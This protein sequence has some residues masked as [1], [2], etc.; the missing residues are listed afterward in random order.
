M[1]VGERIESGPRPEGATAG[2]HTES[3]A[4]ERATSPPAPGA[5]GAGDVPRRESRAPHTIVAIDD[6]PLF[7]E[8]L[9]A[10]F[11]GDKE[12][13]LVGDASNGASALGMVRRLQPDVVLLD[14]GLPSSNGLDLVTQ[15]NRA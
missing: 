11:Q 8:G 12:F 6:H 2:Q 5:G 13:D 9:R 7:C 1:S 4:N 10:L 14:I 15:L 3:S